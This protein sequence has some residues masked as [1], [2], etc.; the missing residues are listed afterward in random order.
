MCQSS[1]QDVP[2]FSKHSD[3]WGCKYVI[4]VCIPY[5]CQNVARFIINILTKHTDLPT[6]IDSDESSAFVTQL[7]RDVAGVL[8]ITL[9]M[10]SNACTEKWNAWMNSCLTQKSTQAENR[11]NT[12]QVAW[13]C[14]KCF[15][16]LQY[17]VPQTHWVRTQLS[18]L[19]TCSVQSLRFENGQKQNG[20]KKPPTPSSQN[21]H[22]LLE[23]TEITYE[24][25]R[26]KA[27]QPY[28]KN[29]ANYNKKS[30]ASKLKEQNYVNVLQP[31]KDQKSRKISCTYFRWTGP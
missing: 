7:K 26:K 27:M 21:A 22:C 13:V 3:S 11:W 2:W 25:V 8:A 5:R 30:N 23:Q 12:I 28:I 18:S 4:F 16:V 31:K 10:H 20:S 29:T 6:T 1:T 17:V 15:P 19:H 9:D 24:D 14:R